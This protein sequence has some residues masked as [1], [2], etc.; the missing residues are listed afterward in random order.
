MKIYKILGVL[1]LS[2]FTFISC[3][4]S[5]LAV[6]GVEG[7]LL[8][9]K[10]P[11]INY[12]V[13]NSGPYAS[14]L[15]VYQGTIKT[16]KVEIYKT[17]YSTRPDTLV[18][19]KKEDGSIEKTVLTTILM[20][21]SI[22]Y[23]TINVSGDQN[24]IESFTFTF[25]QLREGLKIE[26]EIVP[27]PEVDDSIYSFAIIKGF[28]KNAVGSGLLATDGDYNIGDYWE[29]QYYPSTSDG[30]KLLQDLST[31]VTVATRYAGKYRCI[32]GLYYRLGVLTYTTSD[33]P[34]V[35]EIQSVDA[36]TYRVLEY[37]GAFNANPEWYF[38]IQNG[39]ISYPAKW[40]GVPQ[41]LNKNPL[42]TCQT[43]ASDMTEVCG[44]PG[45]NTV[46]N[47]DVNGKDRLIMANGYYTAGSGPRILYQ[48]L[49][50]IVE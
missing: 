40:N 41:L 18:L 34:D 24:S 27:I 50:K 7:G 39:V 9:I 42:I 11:S 15:R 21:N 3:D 22:L 29:F 16:N 38:Q 4:K 36:K 13:G 6:T 8:E 47:D 46:V 45:A 31:K 35:T 32:E 33:W 14:S 44:L 25:D 10:N 43:N 28:S 49:E 23:T 26:K 30:R 19:T 5:E 37:W 2:I 1:L 17:F 12:I 48:V 20:S